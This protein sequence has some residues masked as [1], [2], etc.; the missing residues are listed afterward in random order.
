MHQRNRYVAR[1]PATDLTLLEAHLLTEL[2]AAPELTQ[3]GLLQLLQVDQS[4]LSRTIAR[5]EERG[6]LTA[7]ADSADKRR[8][9]LTLTKE[10]RT[11]VVRSDKIT[12]KTFE[13]LSGALSRREAA[14]IGQLYQAIADGCGHPAGVPRRGESPYRLHQRR[15]TRSFGLLNDSVF[16]SGYT[17][18]QWQILAEL[19]QAPV[20]YR[21][22]ALAERL[23]MSGSALWSQLN[24]LERRGLIERLEDSTDRRVILL[25][26]TAAGREASRAIEEAGADLLRAALAGSNAATVQRWLQTLA[27]FAEYRDTAECAEIQGCSY[28]VPA[29]AP[30][31][32]AARAFLISSLAHHGQGLLAPE[33]LAGQAELTVLI[34]K[35]GRII[36]VLS[37]PR[38]PGSWR[39]TAAGYER[40]KDLPALR[41][42]LQGSLRAFL[43]E[44]LGLAALELAFPPLRAEGGGP[45]KPESGK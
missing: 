15:I 35:E 2:D 5:L 32:T 12:D 30:E 33:T 45:L 26:A 22:A 21:T 40:T 13:Q 14:A 9:R 39:I 23:S 10:G 24:E 17:G 8:K 11:L 28:A 18:I 16:A 4:T 42:A 31:L 27:R 25:R 7:Q 29:T 34:R 37:G 6:L 3:A 44:R 38:T 1:E 19:D 36:G 20:P 41:R 43:E